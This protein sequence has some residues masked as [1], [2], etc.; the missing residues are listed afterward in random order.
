MRALF[1]QQRTAF[2]ATPCASALL[3]RERLS[4]LMALLHDNEEKI[5]AAIDADFGGRPRTETRLLEIF[6]SL[7]GLRYAKRHVADWMRPEPR[8][9]SLWFFPMD[10]KFFTT[11]TFSRH[12]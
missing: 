2:A 3:R 4:H 8:H 1:D 5:I 11:T 9:T 7:E 10:L 12:L 6:P